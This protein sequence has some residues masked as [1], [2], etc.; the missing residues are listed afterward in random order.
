MK[1]LQRE[2]EK[3]FVCTC[4]FAVLAA[5]T[6]F[7]F[8]GLVNESLDEKTNASSE[9]ESES[10]NDETDLS[11][12]DQMFS[13]WEFRWVCFSFNYFELSSPTLKQ[14]IASFWQYRASIWVLVRRSFEQ[15]PGCWV[16]EICAMLVLEKKSF[17]ILNFAW[18]KAQMDINTDVEQNSKR[19]GFFLHLPEEFIMCMQY[20]EEFVMWRLHFVRDDWCR[21]PHACP[22][23]TFFLL[24]MEAVMNLELIKTVPK[25]MLMVLCLILGWRLEKTMR[26]RTKWSQ[27]RRK[28]FD[29]RS[30]QNKV[31]W[32]NCR[33]RHFQQTPT[34][35]SNGL[36]DCSNRGGSTG[37]GLM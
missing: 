28:N 17:E 27:L 8:P 31:H 36:L 29:S 1:I 20:P 12:F 4:L 10:G 3:L 33:K 32:T 2:K 23:W 24:T 11:V 22:P 13:E 25:V 6:D 34:G 19:R 5:M 26:R 7:P 18:L 21:E 9:S 30:L 16:D 14:S 35:K 37:C 15:V